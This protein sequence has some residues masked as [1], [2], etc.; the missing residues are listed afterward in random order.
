MAARPGSL[1][2]EAAKNAAV[3]LTWC[4]ST[5]FRRARDRATKA[6]VSLLVAAP[7]CGSELLRRFENTNDPYIGERLAAA[8]Y[9]AAL[10]SAWD[11][12][13]LADIGQMIADRYFIQNSPPVDLLWRDHLVGLLDYARH[14]GCTLNVPTETRLQ[15]PFDSPWPLE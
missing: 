2:D 4:L 5:T 15:P 8:I 10:Q 13:Q 12:T 9:G 3:I 6:L 11:D 1:D 7:E 14:R